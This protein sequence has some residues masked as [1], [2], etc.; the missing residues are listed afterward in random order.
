MPGLSRCPGRREDYRERTE[1]GEWGKAPMPQSISVRGIATGVLFLFAAYLACGFLLSLMFPLAPLRL[2]LVIV[3]FWHCVVTLLVVPLMA[4]YVAGRVA[5][6]DR[7][8]NGA[9][10]GTSFA[11]YVLVTLLFDEDFHFMDENAGV[12]FGLLPPLFLGPIGGWWG[13][14]LAAG[15]NPLAAPPSS[16]QA[17]SAAER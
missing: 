3:P 4:G 2:K 16:A 12:N 1:R 11:L 8:L 15:I 9:L 7:A 13:G 14:Q 10:T 6:H 5:G 17:T